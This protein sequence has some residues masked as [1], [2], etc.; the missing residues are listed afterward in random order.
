MKPQV[1]VIHGATTFT[2]YEDYLH[3]LQSREVTIDYFKPRSDWKGRLQEVLGESFDVL[4]PSMPNKTNAKYVEWRMWFERVLPFLKDGVIL[5]GHSMG[6]IFLAKYLSEEQFPIK[7]K[8]TMLVAAPYSEVEGETLGDFKLTQ[9]LEHVGAQGGN[10]YLY[11][12]KDD[13]VVPFSQFEQYQKE[14]PR[15]DVRIFED[16]GHFN[17]EQF[18]EIAEDIKRLFFE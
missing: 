6:G 11:H 5:V 18:P 1:V 15:A 7:I 8:A 2:T 17:S 10:I 12:S 14:L 9:P 4:L 3:F 16:R 13:L